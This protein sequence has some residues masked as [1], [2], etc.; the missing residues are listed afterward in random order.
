MSNDLTDTDTET[1]TNSDPQR[2][3]IVFHLRALTR[4][5][6]VTVDEEDAFL[7]RF[8]KLIKRYNANTWV[9]SMSFGLV[10]LDK[11]LEDAF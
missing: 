11:M 4:F 9:F 7:K 1:D 8:K 6:Y 2:Q 5:V 3:D 10:E